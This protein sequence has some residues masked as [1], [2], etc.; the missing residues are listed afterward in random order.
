MWRLPIQNY[1]KL[2]ITE[3]RG[4]KAKYLTWNIPTCQTMSKA[5]HIPSATAQVAPVLLKILAILSDICDWVT[6]PRAIL[7]IR[8]KTTY[9]LVTN[10]PIIYKFLKDFTYYRKKTDMTVGFSCRPFHNILNYRDHRWDLPTI[11]KT[12]YW[13]ILKSSASMFFR[14]TTGI[15]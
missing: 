6:R 10:K 7:E 2:S 8:N 4:N 5:L 12:T 14:T 9:L 1:S 15:Q 11:W 13:H 3:K